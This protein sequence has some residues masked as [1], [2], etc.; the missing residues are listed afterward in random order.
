MYCGVHA[1]A[2]TEV[3][4]LPGWHI[5]TIPSWQKVHTIVTLVGTREFCLH[6][7]G[8]R[9]ILWIGLTQDFHYSGSSGRGNWTCCSTLVLLCMSSGGESTIGM[10]IVP[11]LPSSVP[12]ICIAL[13][14]LSTCMNVYIWCSV[15]LVHALWIALENQEHVIHHWPLNYFPKYFLMLLL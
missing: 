13:A 14:K 8:Y 5:N 10:G 4:M 1:A 2:Y 3:S 15:T 7:P 11:M 6:Y 12:Y 9:L